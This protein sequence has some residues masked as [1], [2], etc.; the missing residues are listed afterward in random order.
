MSRKIRNYFFTERLK[1]INIMKQVAVQQGLT[2]LVVVKQPKLLGK[3]MKV[4]LR[5]KKVILN[6]I[7]TEEI[8]R[9]PQSQKKKKSDRNIFFPD[10]LT[11]KDI[12]V[13]ESQK[14]KLKGLA[15][16][17]PVNV[18]NVDIPP[19]LAYKPSGM[20]I[21]GSVVSEVEPNV[22]QPKVGTVRISWSTG[23][24]EQYTLI[25]GKNGDMWAN[26][27]CDDL[28]NYKIPYLCCGC[29]PCIGIFIR[30]FNS[31]LESQNDIDWLQKG[32]LSV[33]EMFEIARQSNVMKRILF[34][35]LG[36]FMFWL[37]AYLIL[38][39]IAVFVSVIGFLGSI[40]S[41]GIGLAT[42]VIGL[43]S[44]LL[45]LAFAMLYY[46][47]LLAGVIVVA[48]VLIVVMV[49]TLTVG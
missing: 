14:T 37:G 9:F 22:N 6:I 32:A 10:D 19:N 48:S 27:T 49:Q 3:Y 29:C 34:R 43:V 24:L 4:G 30:C 44:Y 26:Y 40:V 13:S 11:I 20:Y 38:R 17:N 8:H 23:E 7:R 1:C 31:L 5:R 36:F 25:C 47:P 18:E 45:T 21:V 2:L 41:F 12:K 28:P 15:S 46:R 39:P 16:K 33:D 35:L 42:F